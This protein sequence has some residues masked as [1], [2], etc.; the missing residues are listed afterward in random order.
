MGERLFDWLLDH[1]MPWLMSAA[2][3]AVVLFVV[4]LP[5]LIY[6][7]YKAER[8]A[9]RKD[10]WLCSAS[11]ER[12]STTYIQ[13]GSVLVPITTYSKHCTQWTEKP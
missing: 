11:V 5:F 3:V 9:L 6:A 13:S 10:E 8:F 12:P 1:V 7:D 4:A 2:I